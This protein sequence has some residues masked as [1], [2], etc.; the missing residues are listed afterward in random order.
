MHCRCSL[1]HR[2]VG[3]DG[4][5]GH[6]DCEGREAQRGDAD[7]RQRLL[8]AAQYQRLVNSVCGA[9]ALGTLLAAVTPPVA[10]MISGEGVAAEA[11]G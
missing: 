10:V 5:A 8:F 3:A 9:V 6:A 4:T 2:A 11:V 1:Y 7:R